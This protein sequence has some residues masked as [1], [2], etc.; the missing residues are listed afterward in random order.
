MVA[1]WYFHVAH[2]VQHRRVREL[3]DERG[4]V[5]CK[6]CRILRLADELREGQLEQSAR[7]LDMFPHTNHYE[8][9]VLLQ[10]G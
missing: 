6:A 8:V 1:D 9:M 5:G 4:N 3:D 7:V 2:P 10:R